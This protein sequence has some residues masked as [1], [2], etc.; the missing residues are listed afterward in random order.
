MFLDVG[1]RRHDCQYLLKE[2]QFVVATLVTGDGTFVAVVFAF[3]KRIRKND[4]IPMVM[5]WHRGV[6]Q[7][8]QA[9][10]S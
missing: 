2:T 9:D 7:N 6:T 1:L 3:F 5:V 10:K 8:N 4:P